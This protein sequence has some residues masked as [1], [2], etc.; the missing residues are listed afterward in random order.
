MPTKRRPLA[1][2]RQPQVTA[3]AVEA[4]K[5]ARALGRR[6]GWVDAHKPLHRELGI[7]WFDHSPLHVTSETPPDYIR[8]NPAQAPEWRRAWELRQAL[9]AAEAAA[10]R[11]AA[12]E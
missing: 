8:R 5:R 12:A 9:L 6:E 7:P 1:H 11:E 2:N 10:D 4:W 3:A